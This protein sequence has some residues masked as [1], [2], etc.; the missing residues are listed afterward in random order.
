MQADESATP[1]VAP[2]EVLETALAR[3]DVLASLAAAPRHRAELQAE[4]D[5]SKTTA[6]R[7]VRSFDDQGLLRRTD[8][9]YALTPL[10]RTVAAAVERFDDTVRTACRLAPLLDAF[11][12]APVELPVEHFADARVT[13]PRP[14]APSSPV[15]QSCELYF[16]TDS[17]TIRILDR[18]RFV[19]PVFLE[20]VYEA[21]VEN[22]LTAEAVLPADLV[23]GY[24]EACPDL[25]R[26]LPDLPVELGYRVHEDVPVGL[27]LYDEHVELRAYDDETGVPVC[28][29][30]T[31]DPD[32]VAWAESVYEH[33]REAARPAAAVD[34]LP[35]WLPQ[36]EPP[37]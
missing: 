23:A 33:Y 3:S 12:D 34:D 32:A 20:Q 7:I 1:D 25:H 16:R 28:M 15:E 13:R 36:P 8:D 37:F 24:V 18:V 19:P 27:S 4:H 10:G 14:D 21:G 26:D 2:D 6:H 29:V 30:D 5:L 22:E 9:G 17:D 35:D 31:D 11:A